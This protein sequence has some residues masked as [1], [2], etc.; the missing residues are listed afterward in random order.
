MHIVTYIAYDK[1][2]NYAKY[3][4]GSY[5]SISKPP[6]LFLFNKNFVGNIFFS[7]ID[8]IKKFPGH[9]Y[10]SMR[11]T[12]LLPCNGQGCLLELGDP[13]NAL[14]TLSLG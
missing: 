7:E 8:T 5:W 3:S 13:C 1:D 11:L 4:R 9:L 2:C 14:C 6:V 12:Q 10:I